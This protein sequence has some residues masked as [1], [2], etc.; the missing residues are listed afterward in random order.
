MTVILLLRNC[1]GFFEHVCDYDVRGVLLRDL[2]V[3]SQGVHVIPH[4]L[5]SYSTLRAFC[6]S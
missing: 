3:G 5:V 4:D 6:R 1:W 2:G